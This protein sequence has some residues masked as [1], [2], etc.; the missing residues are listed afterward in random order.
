MV[1][2]KSIDFGRSWTPLQFYSS[3][4]RKVYGRAPNAPVTRENEQEAL[5]SDAAH[6]QQLGG[7]GGSGAGGS[8]SSSADRVA[9]AMMEGRPSGFDFETSPV[10]QV[11]MI[12]QALDGCK[13]HSNFQD[14]VTATDIRVVFN[15]L[16]PHQADL[17]GITDNSVVEKSSEIS[18]L[19]LVQNS[20]ASSLSSGALLNSNGISDQ[21]RDSLFYRYNLPIMVLFVSISCQFQHG[22]F[23]RWR[24]MQVQRPCV[25]MRSR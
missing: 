10:L 17:Y 8:T 3:Q 4:C 13:N 1:L 16:T 22:R 11:F 18:T 12:F 5:C 14:W 19:T 21:I 20:S 9:F 7:G 24:S 2:E 6:H 25:K 15:R 23:C